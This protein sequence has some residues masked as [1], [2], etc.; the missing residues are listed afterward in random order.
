MQTNLGPNYLA[1]EERKKER[2]RELMDRCIERE[3][4]KRVGY[5]YCSFRV[6]EIYRG[7][8]TMGRAILENGNCWKTKAVAYWWSR[9]SIAEEITV[10]VLFGSK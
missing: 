7:S 5:E 6:W 4:R 1:M 9:Q 8:R 3:S 2:G 10:N